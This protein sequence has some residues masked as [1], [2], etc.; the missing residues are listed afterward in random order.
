MS[1][2]SVCNVPRIVG[3]YRARVGYH[4]ICSPEDFFLSCWT[5][6]RSRG[7]FAPRL[8]VTLLKVVWSETQEASRSSATCFTIQ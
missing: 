8:G 4:A 2:G 7:S 3:L 1:H 6:G 5:R